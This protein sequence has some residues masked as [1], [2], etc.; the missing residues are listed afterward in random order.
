MTNRIHFLW[1]LVWQKEDCR[2]FGVSVCKKGS[3]GGYKAIWGGRRRAQWQVS[4]ENMM[5]FMEA[6][7]LKDKEIGVISSISTDVHVCECN[8]SE[9]PHIVQLCWMVAL[10]AGQKSVNREWGYLLHKL[11]PFCRSRHIWEWWVKVP[12]MCDKRHWVLKSSM[13]FVWYQK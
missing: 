3:K 4:Q 12:V 10:G 8:Q 5:W 2:C 7:T 13:E 6:I 1:V 9:N 11:K